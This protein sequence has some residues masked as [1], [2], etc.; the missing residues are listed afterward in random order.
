VREVPV[1]M[2]CHGYIYFLNRITI[3]KTKTVL[4]SHRTEIKMEL[5]IVF[6]FKKV[7]YTISILA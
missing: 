3:I 4:G 2:K 5:L 6:V 1:Y 7:T